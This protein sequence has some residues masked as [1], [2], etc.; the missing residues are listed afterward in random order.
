MLS[1]DYAR[2]DSATAAIDRAAASLDA[3]YLGGGTNLVDLM[4][5]ASSARARV[6]DVTALA[7]RDRRAADGNILIGAAVKNTALASDR[8]CGRAIRCWPARSWRARARRSATWRRWAATC[9]SGRAATYFYDDAAALQQAGARRGLRC[10]RRLQPH[11]RDPGRLARLRR[12]ASVGHVRGARGARRDRPCRGPAG[13][14]DDRVHRSPPPARR[15]PEIETVLEPGEL[16][17]A[18]S[19]PEAPVSPRA[20]IARCATARATPS[21]WSRSAPRSI[22]AWTANLGRADR[23]GRR[24]A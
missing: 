3:R 12:D 6:I 14:A 11:P 1:F 2:P 15:P 23:A 8:L 19:L 10:A 21:R 22:W 24:R 18:S 5:E 20:A 16:I 9:C 13:R 17:T 4:R 7:D